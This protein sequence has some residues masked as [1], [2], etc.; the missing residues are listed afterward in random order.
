MEQRTSE[1]AGFI[2]AGGQSTRMGRDKALLELSGVPLVV[3]AARL[4]ESAVGSASVIGHP[5]SY[6]SLQLRV[7]ADDWPGAGPLGGIATALRASEA[8]WNLIVACDLPYLTKAWLDFLV[9]CALGSQA[10]AVLPMNERGAEP[11]CAMYHK[12]C[13]SAVWLALDRGT[14]KVTDCLA[15]VHVEHLEPAEWK[16][17]DSKGFL[18]KN[19]NS[20]DDYEE[21]KAKLEGHALR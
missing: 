8:P 4:V 13:E 7:I 10:D 19:M 11:L 5:E 1:V 17:F 2:L 20:Q 16:C 14:R 21:A 12:R 6:R 15:G 9:K 18:F 3:R